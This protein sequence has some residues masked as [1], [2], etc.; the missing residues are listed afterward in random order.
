MDE[1]TKIII[2]IYLCVYIYIYIFIYVCVYMCVYGPGDL[3]SIPGRFISKT[4]K[5]VLDT[6]LLNT[7]HYKVSRVRWI[8]K[9]LRPPLDL[10]VVANEKGAFWS[11]LIKVAVCIYVYICLCKNVYIWACAYICIYMGVFIYVYICV[12]IYIYIYIYI[13]HIYPTPLLGQDMT[14][15]QSF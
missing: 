14:Q 3:V 5:M 11:S 7:Q 9:E 15:G 12:C 1:F 8:K 6:S 2:Y 13:Y 4:L 10:G